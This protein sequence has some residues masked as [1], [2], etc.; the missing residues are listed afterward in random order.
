MGIAVDIDGNILLGDRNNKVILKYD[1]IKNTLEKLPINDEVE[2][3]DLDVDKNGFIYFYDYSKSNILRYDS[4]TKNTTVILDE[5]SAFYR[6]N[7]FRRKRFL[8]RCE[9]W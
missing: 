1:L 7:Y 9:C 6:T 8:I 3:R 4:K 5:S 2:P